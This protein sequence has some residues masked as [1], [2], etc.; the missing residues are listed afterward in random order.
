LSL[1]KTEEQTNENRILRTLYL[2][3][4]GIDFSNGSEFG[5]ERTWLTVMIGLVRNGCKLQWCM[6]YMQLK[7][8]C[9]ALIFSLNSSDVFV[10]LQVHV[11]LVS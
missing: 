7:I 6:M 4:E 10:N 11:C 2:W 1:K 8:A 3:A 5:E 9:C